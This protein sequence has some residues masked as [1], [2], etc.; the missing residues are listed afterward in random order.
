MPKT[1]NRLSEYNG[2][3]SSGRT[4]KIQIPLK[5]N[6][7]Q[8]DSWSI[9]KTSLGN[10]V[11][12]T[13]ETPLPS[14]YSGLHRVL[15]SG[16]SQSDVEISFGTATTTASSNVISGLSGITSSQFQWRVYGNGIPAGTYITE[17]VNATTVK[18]S[19]NATLTQTGTASLRISQYAFTATDPSV[20]G[21]NNKEYMATISGSSI[22]FI[23]PLE[24]SFLDSISAPALASLQT[25]S[26]VTPIYNHRWTAIQG[27]NALSVVSDVYEHNS[28]YSL[29]I[30]PS[31]AGPVTIALNSVNK[32]FIEDNS[33][34][35]S[36]NAK[37]Y[38]NRQTS[39][40][41]SLSASSYQIGDIGPG[42]GIV[43]ITPDT[44]GNTT[45]NYFEA[46][47]GLWNNGNA[48][49]AVWWSIP[50]YAETVSLAYD[51][52]IGTGYQNTLDI[53][54]QGNTPNTAASICRAY[55]NK[56]FN[57][58]FLP[59]KNELIEMGNNYRVI[60]NID[61]P[62]DMYWTSTESTAMYALGTTLNTPIASMSNYI[63]NVPI[64]L[65]PS[66]KVRPVRMFNVEDVL[67]PEAVRTIVYPGRFTTI[68]S[69]VQELPIS[70]EDYYYLDVSITVSGHEGQPFYITTPN[71]IE[72]FLY[73]R[74]PYVY[75]AKRSM[76]DFYWH[77]DSTQ[78]NPSAPLH[79]LIDCM[80]TGA[81]DVF[82]EYMRIYVYEPG[83]LGLLAEQFRT[84]NVHSTLVNPDYVNQR[85]APWLSQFN[86]HKLKKNI[87]YTVN[88]ITNTTYTEPQPMFESDG[89]KEAFIKWQ[90][91]NGYYGRAAGTT[92][93]LKEAAKQVLHYTKNSTQSTYFVSIT[94]HYGGDPFKI[95]IRTL[96]NETFDC[97]E[98]GE[99]SSALLDA[100][101]LAKPMG[102][103]VYHQALENLEFRIGDNLGT[104][105][106]GDT[107]D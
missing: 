51:E 43:F 29:F 3:Q 104:Y 6:V 62:S 20:V 67:P 4:T 52:V 47:P 55:T 10:T 98:D 18:I 49:P 14:E 5:G 2:L 8:I 95:L 74:N 68:R 76:P 85:Y 63:K 44:A 17:V 32:M 86:G 28:R 42:G 60:P 65:V 45:G 91:K 57:D 21:V 31:G 97:T 16:F 66:I 80:M 35:F 99:E 81:R 37:I 59:S 33:K 46:A 19:E 69:N 88:S 92:D 89:A 9:T 93:A 87:Q 41:C 64:G 84:N 26:I 79:R 39:V 56:G 83:Q 101:E 25:S 50:T 71:L 102:Y 70:N 90:L 12:L 77:L 94:P 58:W 22:I 40:D 78:E 96:V 11:E 53:I 1:T 82:D 38:S 105:P 13:L 103:K 34:D 7:G 107:V 73:N 15:V 48:D 24:W 54:A 36:F 61:S 100:I 75:S 23:T 106:L 30:Q 27:T 72:D